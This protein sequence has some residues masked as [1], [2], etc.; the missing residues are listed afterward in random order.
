[1]AS[2]VLYRFWSDADELLYVGITARPWERWKQHRA[3][4]PW[5]EEVVKVTI[6]NFA[7]RAEVKSAESV[8]IKA[9]GPRYNIAEVPKATVVDEAEE[10]WDGRHVPQ[11]AFVDSWFYCSCRP[12]DWSTQP[13]RLDFGSGPIKS[14]E[15]LD[16]RYS[17][18]HSAEAAWFQNQAE[19]GVY[20]RPE[21]YADHVIESVAAERWAEAMAVAR[22]RVKGDERQRKKSAKFVLEVWPES[23]HQYLPRQWQSYVRGWL[24]SGL[25]RDD[26]REALMVALEAKHVPM[27]RMWKYATGVLARMQRELNE[28]AEAH[29]QN[30]GA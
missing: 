5:W 1:M 18:Y 2:Q 14:R 9:E 13:D 8:A 20:I 6:E 24:D 16:E 27:E 23:L 15:D 3:E 17:A 12:P 22:A 28:A 29:L 7:T 10:T 26:V 11:I 21:D 19:L 4:K 25:T 30:G